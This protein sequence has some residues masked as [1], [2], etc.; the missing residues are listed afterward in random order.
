MDRHFSSTGH[1]SL[2]TQLYHVVEYDVW[3]RAFFNAYKMYQLFG[4]VRVN[5]YVC[6]KNVGFFAEKVV[7]LALQCLTFIL[8]WIPCLPTAIKWSVKKQQFLLNALFNSSAVSI[9]CSCVLEATIKYE[10]QQMYFQILESTE[11]VS[12]R[13]F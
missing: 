5:K 9:C 10:V 13:V 3:R 12:T 4:R 11:L 1:S 7:L 2:T 8:I 6:L